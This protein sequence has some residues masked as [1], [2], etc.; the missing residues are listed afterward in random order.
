VIRKILLE[1]ELTSDEVIEMLGYCAVVEVIGISKIK[2]IK[3]K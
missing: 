2:P 1:V 3:K